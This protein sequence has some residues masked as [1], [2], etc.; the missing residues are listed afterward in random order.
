MLRPKELLWQVINTG[1][2]HHA[3]NE[4]LGFEIHTGDFVRF[5]R[6]AFYVRE[7]LPSDGSSRQATHARNDTDGNLFENLYDEEQSVPNQLRDLIGVATS[8][9]EASQRS[10]EHPSIVRASPNRER[11]RI[12]E[13]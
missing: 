1:E 10:Q 8:L 3:E 2:A 13:Q 4:G 12:G 5:G 6:N 7:T 9:E 11:N